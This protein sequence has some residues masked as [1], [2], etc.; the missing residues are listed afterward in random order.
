MNKA[1]ISC[2]GK[3]YKI[4]DHKTCDACNGTGLQE[5]MDV[6]G[7]F[8]GVNTQARQKFDLDQDQDIPCDKCKGKGEIEITETCPS[9]E[10][11]GE[12]NVC[13]E[14]GKVLNDS[15]DYCSQCQ[16]KEII[17]VLHPACEMS[18]LEVG[19]T[20]KGRITRVEKYGVFVSLNNQVWGL[21]RTGM[22]GH[23]VGD[24]IF[25][26]V[27]E[28]KPQ[29]GEVD[30][31]PATFK[32]EY[33][34]VNLKKNLAR[35]KIDDINSKTMGKTVRI[36]GEVIQI[37]QT[38][39]PTI[40]TISD[41]TGTTWCAAFD[42]PGVRVYPH[43]NVED[44]VEVMGEVNMHSGKIQIESESIDLLEGEE[45]LEARKL[46]D[47]AIDERAEPAET[48]FLIESEILNR[49]KPT[50]RKAAKA[51]RRAVLD[52]RS[53]LVRHHADADGICAG[54]GM[55]KAVIPLLK[56]INADSDAEWHYFKRAPSKA[57]FYELEDVVKDL[58]YALEDLE[59]HGQKLPL[60]VLLDNGSTEEDILALMKAKIY[61]IE[62]VVIDHH[63]PG[64]VK[65]GKVEVDEYV[66]VHVNP[67]LVGGDSQITA[68]AL[69]VEVACMVNPEVRDKIQ[70]LPGIAA[71][72]DHAHSKEVE[73]YIKL[74]EE[75]GYDL[76]N[77][78]RI[79]S[80]IDFEAY[81]LR[82][83]HGR[84]IM[85]T[86]LDLEN[87]EKHP[88]LINALHN[89][90][91]KRVKNQ[92]KAAL[93]NLKSQDLPNG[94]LF[95]V[96]DVEKYSH[97][98]TFPAPGKTCGFVHD[99]MVQQNAEGKPIITL[100]YGP[101]FGVIR[102]TDEVN[103]IYGFNLNEIVWKLADKI[104]E[105]GIDGGGHEC[106]GS[107]KFLEGLSTEVLSAFANEVS[108]LGSDEK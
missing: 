86:I 90:Y 101:D 34:L 88:A 79:A 53:I 108:I 48:N 23:N 3:G 58:S 37:Q 55:E 44:I 91:Q 76:E 46:I 31:G 5:T 28:L 74:A 95:N 18:D 30:L 83:M 6:K 75:K 107:L 106:A 73:Q 72:G 43:I 89:E 21:M 66:D 105:A 94:V 52:G 100:A 4:K 24:N 65:E 96:L 9:C 2:K 22:P 33:E 84:G 87:Q 68:G 15:S 103:E 92:L 50:M 10:G 54:V 8:K 57:P 32:G 63:F 11:K 42:E 99:H 81:F 26:K 41:E 97:R 35:T 56:E 67:Y 70:H 47:Q 12:I 40:F 7:H 60:I 36:V 16:K 17:Y 61:D 64:E 78:D 77:L 104:P 82:F 14:C 80:C 98:F 27:A 45:A 29:R 20:Y 59:R 13:R 25:V 39:G 69:A 1:C 38:S 49:L 85:D 102:A 71:V 19:S 93:P 62:I 51:I